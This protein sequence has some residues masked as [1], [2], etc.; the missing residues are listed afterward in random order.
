LLG[1]KSKI[2]GLIVSSGYGRTARD[3]T[4]KVEKAV[5]TVGDGWFDCVYQCVKCLMKRMMVL[6]IACLHSGHCVVVV[7]LLVQP[8][9]FPFEPGSLR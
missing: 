7:R 6:Q 8:G 3:V 1:R 4:V 2:D 5:Y 9:A